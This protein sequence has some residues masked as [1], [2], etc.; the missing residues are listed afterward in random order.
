MCVFGWVGVTL[1][2]RLLPKRAMAL[3]FTS[4][5]KWVV[6]ADKTGEVYRY[7]LD[8]LDQS[9]GE[10]LLGHFSVLLDMVRCHQNHLVVYILKVYF[11]FYF[12]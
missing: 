5:D 6:V 1:S 10:H 8:S 3:C 12:L 7:R 11:D 9:P 4:D 2:S